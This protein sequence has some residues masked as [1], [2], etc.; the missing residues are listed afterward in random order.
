M[1]CTSLTSVIFISLCFATLRS[2]AVALAADNQLSEQE[3]EAG[4]QLLFNGRDHTGW[5]CNNGKP[6]AT[7]VE[8]GAIVPFKSGG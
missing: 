6:I 5:K 3:K 2:D 1:S 4:W 7:P 8:N